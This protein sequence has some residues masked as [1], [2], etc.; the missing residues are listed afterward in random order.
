[1][2]TG[3]RTSRHSTEELEA[4]LEDG[5]SLGWALGP[6]DIVID[7]EAKTE[8]G[9]QV[10]GRES[11]KRL[12]VDHG[13]DLTETPVITNPSGGS[14]LYFRKPPGGEF[15]KTIDAYPGIEF[16]REGQYVVVAGSSHWQGGSY[17]TKA[18]LL[19]TTPETIPAGLL[20][21]LTR[22]VSDSKTSS[23]AELTAEQLEIVLT[24]L[25][26][27]DFRGEG[28]GKWA[29][30]MMACHAATGG[31]A[32]A[33]D[34]FVEWC[35]GDPHYLND[36]TI[37]KRWDSCKVDGGITAA[38]LFQIL[39]ERGADVAGAL[40]EL[41]LATA[42]TEF[43]PQP[44]KGDIFGGEDSRNSLD[45]DELFPVLASEY[46]VRQ[47]WNRRYLCDRVVQDGMCMMIVAPEKSLKTTLAVDLG[48]SLAAG[49][50]F[51]GVPEFK[52]EEPVNVL[53]MVG[54]TYPGE[55]QD[56][57][58]R[59]APA[60]G[61]DPVKGLS[62]LKWSTAL[63]AFG[64]DRHIEALKRLW[65]K[66]E[67]KVAIID[68]FYLCVTAGASK[69]VNSH[70]IMAMGPYLHRISQAAKDCGVTLI[71]IHH[72][73]KGDRR[74]GGGP[75]YTTRDD[76]SGAGFAAWMRQWMLISRLEDYEGDGKHKLQIETGGF[77][78]SGKYIVNVDEG[79]Q[80]TEGGRIWD[81]QVEQ[82][83][84]NL[85]KQ[86]RD[87]AIRERADREGHENKVCRI[88]TEYGRP[89][90]ARHVHGRMDDLSQRKC[91]NL[92]EAM[93]AEGK[94]EMVSDVMP[95]GGGPRY[96]G[97]AINEDYVHPDSPT[98]DFGGAK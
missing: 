53:I 31:D 3:W 29:D 23:D 37:H 45:E 84:E 55:I 13:I 62:N 81:V 54:E 12:C 14:H 57:L 9:H 69:P 41:N 20:K 74:H 75:R 48:V 43:E 94:L 78:H 42:K 21:S 11:L 18:A 87:R 35:Y 98:A 30:L 32:L 73:R 51:L 93:T 19:G 61:V 2:K 70:D 79:S 38:T 88:I 91:T 60:R 97:Y 59:I 64:S 36:G 33:R 25:N 34:H 71:G 82:L 83:S 67:I 63:P 24:R 85:A 6:T 1:L 92:L 52:V 17:S 4:Y 8:T 76:I 27:C 22:P 77:A 5:H 58:N 26:P 16:L 50:E 72:T 68:P 28:G 47:D 15:R 10:D 49:K 96:S 65:L 7:V 44:V 66:H 95:K 39:K 56:L 86:E 90:S 46:V 89:V 80:Y 40:T